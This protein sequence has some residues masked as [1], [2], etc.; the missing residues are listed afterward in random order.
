MT[1][2][3]AQIEGLRQHGSVKFYD[4]GWNAALDKVL[5]LVDAA[6]RGRKP[7]DAEHLR[8]AADDLDTTAWK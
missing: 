4:H 1:S 5:A 6:E 3:R 7:M 2:L 8:K